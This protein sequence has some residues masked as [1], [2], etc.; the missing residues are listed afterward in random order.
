[1]NTIHQIQI[2]FPELVN[3]SIKQRF[4]LIMS[5][6]SIFKPSNTLNTKILR[7]YYFDIIKLKIYN[8]VKI[9]Y[10]INYING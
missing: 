3:I 1:M 6:I 7:P 4:S 10:P 5:A 2:N 8:D 9:E